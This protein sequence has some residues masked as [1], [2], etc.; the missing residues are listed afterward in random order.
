MR[1]LPLSGEER[2]RILR[3]CGVESFEELTSDIPE[4]LRL[5]GLLDFDPALSESE[6]LEHL[7]ELAEK[8][9]GAKMTCHLGQGVY[10]HSWPVAI[11]QL[12]NRGEFFTA[13][14]PYQPE[15]SQGTLQTIFEFQSMISD[16]YGL[17]VANASLYDGATAVVE[18]ALMAARMQNIAPAK[19]G[20]VLLVSEGTYDRVVAVL[21]TYL[22]PLNISVVRW[23][24]SVSKFLSSADINPWPDLGGKP[25]VGAV[26]QSPNKWGLVEDWSELTRFAGLLQ[27][28]SI[29]YVAHAHSP[30][31]F[32]APGEANVDLAVGEG[33]ALGLPMGYGG[34]HLG[35]LACR[36]KDVR[37]MPGRVVG[38]TEDLHGNRAF[39]I[40][41]AGRE[42]HIRREKATS[43]ICSNQNL[44]AL[45]TGIYMTLMG[46]AGLKQVAETSRS[47]ACYARE[48]LKPRLAKKYP[49]IRVLDGDVFNEIALLV[50]QKRSLWFDEVRAA[51]ERLGILPGCRVEVPGASGFVGA[52]VT[53]FTEKHSRRD[54]ERVVDILCGEEPS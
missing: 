22:E 6:L 42:Q 16:L 18:A 35:L 39:C 43:N 28:K 47:A 5:K 7:G 15:I 2:Q 13:Y 12:T 24:A 27:T 21:R 53:A 51:G 50:P 36:M 10:D 44:M 9:I 32:Q 46:P 14:T 38:A 52:L 26:M 11:D 31:I 4:S 54:I 34:P 45:R 19:T 1:Y 37:Q 25:V 29:A 33:Q 48:L 30:A 3:L 17:E 8:N 41:L 49:E 40:T 23:E 20:G